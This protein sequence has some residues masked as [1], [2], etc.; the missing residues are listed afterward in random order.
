MQIVA[1][2]VVVPLRLLWEAFAAVCKALYRWLL[3]PLG[4]A[5]AWLFTV[6]VVV[7]VRALWTALAW[8]GRHLIAIPAAWLY[9]VLLTPLGRGLARLGHYLIVVPL[10][11]LYTYVLA[12][13][14]APSPS[15]RT[16]WSW[17]RSS[18]C[19]GTCSGRCCAASAWSSSGPGARPG[20]SAASCGCA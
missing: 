17:C 15:S 13:S 5:L 19:G 9:R 16:T 20:T 14:G 3:A 6:L 2:I 7:P 8:L 10:T 1:L 11:A 18:R 4:R 12:P